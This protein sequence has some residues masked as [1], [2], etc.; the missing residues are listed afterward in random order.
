MSPLDEKQ[1][2][3]DQKLELKKAQQNIQYEHQINQVSIR[4]K[5][6]KTTLADDYEIAQRR[7]KCAEEDLTTLPK[8]ARGDNLT[9]RQYGK[10]GFMRNVQEQSK[11]NGNLPHVPVIRPDKDSV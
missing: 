9:I 6:N 1:Q 5:V 3:I 10:R 7:P 8:I 2:Q 11:S 4:C